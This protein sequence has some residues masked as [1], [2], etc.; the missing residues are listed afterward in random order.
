[1]KEFIKQLLSYKL[2]AP[3]LQNKAFIVVYHDVSETNEPVYNKNYSTSLTNFKA[4]LLF[5]KTHFNQLS[6]QEF[7]PLQLIFLRLLL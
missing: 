3:L 5:F 4:H 2:L 7:R 1:M 6:F